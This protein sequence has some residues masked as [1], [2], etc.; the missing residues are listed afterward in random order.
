MNASMGKPKNKRNNQKGCDPS[1]QLT[2]DSSAAS[3]GG[4]KLTNDVD[5][6]RQTPTAA[7]KFIEK[8]PGTRYRVCTKQII[9][10]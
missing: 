9:G 8:V 6:A 10:E 3:L 2:A 7:A 4:V 1:G 5:S